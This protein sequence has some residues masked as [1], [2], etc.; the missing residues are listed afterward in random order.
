VRVLSYVKQKL[1]LIMAKVGFWL[2]GAKG[3]LAGA[4]LQKGE[5]GTVARQLVVPKNP[6]TKPQMLQRVAFGTVASAAK[7]MLGVIGIA[8]EGYEN[9]KLGRREF[10]RINVN[11]AKTL[12]L[13]NYNGATEGAFSAKGYSQLI[14]NPYIMSKGSLPLPLKWTVGVNHGVLSFPTI[15]AELA[16]GDYTAA[17]LWLAL[18]GLKP[19]QQLTR[20]AIFTINGTNVAYVPENDPDDCIRYSRFFSDR[21]VLKEGS[22]DT[23]RIGD[24][25]TAA[26][27]LAC[28]NS[29]VDTEQTA[30]SMLLSASNITIGASTLADTEK[31]ALVAATNEMQHIKYDDTTYRQVGQCFFISQFVGGQWCYSNSEMAVVDA[32]KAGVEDNTTYGLGAYNAIQTYLKKNGVNSDLYTQQ[33]GDEDTINGSDF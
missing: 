1:L 28:L 26:L 3:K 14:P 6:Q 19:G 31:L 15:E 22:G 29:L 11:R 2:Q 18:F 5:K 20:C 27:V 23:I 24:S 8:M 7:Y 12:A 21:L 9:K 17:D 33:G 4:S 16:D 25:T 13:A 30:A 10:V 32:R